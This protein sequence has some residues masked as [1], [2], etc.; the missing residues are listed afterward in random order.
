MGFFTISMRD[1]TWS[2]LR[3]IGRRLQRQFDPVTEQALP[4]HLIELL[5]RIDAGQ[6]STPSSNQTQDP[7]TSTTSMTAAL[8]I[9][10]TLI[11]ALIFYDLL[12]YAMSEPKSALALTFAAGLTATLAGTAWL[13]EG[14]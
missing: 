14:E 2:R 11:A 6:P 9:T 7:H 5:R 12:I 4:E 13:V 3:S 10:G 1:D 8:A